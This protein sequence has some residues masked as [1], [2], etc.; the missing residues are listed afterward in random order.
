MFILMA[1]SIEQKVNKVKPSG[2]TFFKEK[3]SR[4]MN[5]N[6]IKSVG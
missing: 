3:L 2:D 5:R 4:E 6:N 1:K